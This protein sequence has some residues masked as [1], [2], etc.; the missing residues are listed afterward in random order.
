M[1]S[2]Q[3]THPSANR[4]CTFLEMSSIFI[5]LAHSHGAQFKAGFLRI[6]TLGSSIPHFGRKSARW[7]EKRERRWCVVS[8]SYL[9]AME[10]PGEVRS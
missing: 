1:I 10:E 7:H 2:S 5:T 3:M 4:L 8:D 9:V 6:E